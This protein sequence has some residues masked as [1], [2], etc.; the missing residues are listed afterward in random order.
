MPPVQWFYLCSHSWDFLCWVYSCMCYRGTH[1]QIKCRH[2]PSR[3]GYLMLKRSYR[4]I[5]DCRTEGSRTRLRWTQLSWENA[6]PHQGSSLPT[7]NQFLPPLNVPWLNP[8]AC[9][10]SP[11]VSGLCSYTPLGIF[12]PGCRTPEH[13]YCLHSTSHKI[14]DL[15]PKDPR[16]EILSTP[17]SL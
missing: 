11:F 17:L 13:K 7:L 15:S 12:P 1:C 9:H 16:L 8:T 6:S 3:G 14:T 5:Q 10:I 4:V 2:L